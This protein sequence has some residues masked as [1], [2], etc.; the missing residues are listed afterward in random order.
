MAKLLLN[1]VRRKK[2]LENLHKSLHT[3]PP[4]MDYLMIV[5]EFTDLLN[6]YIEDKY[7][8]EDMKILAKYG[9]A[10][11]LNVYTGRH[12]NPHR[13]D[14]YLEDSTTQ[15]C[16][17]QFDLNGKLFPLE[18]KRYN[19]AYYPKYHTHYSHLDPKLPLTYTEFGYDAS[20][21]D[22]IL[23]RSLKT[24]FDSKYNWISTERY[25]PQRD[26]NLLS[27][28]VYASKTF[29]DLLDIN[30]SFDKFR[31]DI[32]DLHMPKQNSS[33]VDKKKCILHETHVKILLDNPVTF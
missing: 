33:S 7:P 10:H 24:E 28:L 19:T 14:I 4:T 30:P 3:I 13:L 27:K 31:D 29:E 6:P 16:H 17:I 11:P 21:P 1:A 23:P 26:Y 18:S 25:K 8:Q 2:L 5:S 15:Y 12:T 9:S 20:H 22:L 32:K